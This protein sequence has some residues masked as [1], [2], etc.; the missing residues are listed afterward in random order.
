MPK[1]ATLRGS[2]SAPSIAPSFT[3]ERFALDNGLR[4]VVS[5]DRSSPTV[6]VTLAYDVGMRSEPEGRTGFAH[7]F[8]HFMFQGSKNLPKGEFDKV[9]ENNGGVNNGYTR[10][11]KTVY[12]EVL[13]STALEA[14][15]FAEA[16]R[17]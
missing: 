11:D 15:L 4:V 10:A 3:V 1:T 16:D 12:Y 6:D 7:L 13:T 5:P 17:L 8:E 2:R 9:I 14:V